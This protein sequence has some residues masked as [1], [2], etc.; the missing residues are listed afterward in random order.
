[1]E[2]MSSWLIVFNMTRLACLESTLIAV[3]GW[4]W[5]DLELVEEEVWASGRNGRVGPPV[6]VR[7]YCRSSAVIH[8]ISH[9]NSSIY[10]AESYCRSKSAR[11][12]ERQIDTQCYVCNITHNT[13]DETAVVFRL[14]DNE[15][16]ARVC[17]NWH[18]TASWTKRR[19]CEE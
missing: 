14:P 17:S 19:D 11:W 10:W 13:I 2:I 7:D 15:Q 6:S 5:A 3:P 16:D 18:R 4:L 1:M 9:I 8:P 12:S